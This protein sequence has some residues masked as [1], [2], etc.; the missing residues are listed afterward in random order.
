[1]RVIDTIFLLCA[2]CALLLL[3]WIGAAHGQNPYAPHVHGGNVPDWYDAACC[4]NQDC[5][6]VDNPDDVEEGS[7]DGKT[8]YLYKP[9]KALF[10]DYMIKPSRDSRIHVCLRWGNPIC[11]YIPLN[12]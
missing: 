2:V 8:T 3:I 1:M 11:I 10:L 9:D 7:K 5:H 4:S 6:P 12:S